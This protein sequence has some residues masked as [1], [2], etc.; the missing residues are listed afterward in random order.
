MMR[1]IIKYFVVIC[2][3][4]LLCL[5]ENAVG[6]VEE[7]EKELPLFRG[8]FR[9]ENAERTHFFTFYED[10]HAEVGPI[11]PKKRLGPQNDLFADEV[12][13]GNV[14]DCSNARYRCMT[15]SRIVFAVPRKQLTPT[16]T[17]TLE[18]TVFTVHECLRGVGKVCQVALIQ[19]DCQWINEK[20]T[21]STFPGGRSKSPDTGPLV[22]FIYNEDCGITSWGSAYTENA[23]KTLVWKYAREYILQGDVGPLKR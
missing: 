20:R 8:S 23:D 13:G 11:M 15:T 12:L 19:A 18:G 2:M 14:Y 1:G 6:A 4:L 21:C 10:G 3:S 9:F 5:T 7:A 16:S 22:Y 17:Y